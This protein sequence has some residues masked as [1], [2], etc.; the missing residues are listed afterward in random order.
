MKSFRY[1]QK[2]DGTWEKTV[3]EVDINLADY[4]WHQLPGLEGVN[5]GVRHEDG[6][7]VII[8]FPEEEEK[9]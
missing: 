6:G 2:P 8:P 3:E 5:V 4:Q 1:N 7:K 9:S